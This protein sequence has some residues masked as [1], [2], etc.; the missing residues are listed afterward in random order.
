MK[1]RKEGRKEGREEDTDMLNWN[2][3]KVQVDNGETRSVI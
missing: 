3:T 2:K 1:G